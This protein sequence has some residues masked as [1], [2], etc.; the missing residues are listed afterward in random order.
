MGLPWFNQYKAVDKVS[1]ARTEYSGSSRCWIKE[2][3]EITCSCT[4]SIGIPKK[5]PPSCIKLI[6]RMINSPSYLNLE[7]LNSIKKTFINPF[8][9]DRFSMHF[10]VDKVSCARTEYSG[11]SRCWI[12]ESPAV[13][14]SCTYYFIP[15]APT[16]ALTSSRKDVKQLVYFQI[17]Q[18]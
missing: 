13:T 6:S 10:A 1:C 18:F 17:L 9:S 3:P 4:Y 15:Q 8:H 5:T 2:S 7:L 14:C 16:S 11:S 12:K